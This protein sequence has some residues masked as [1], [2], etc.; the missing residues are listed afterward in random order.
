MSI[1]ALSAWLILLYPIAT[2]LTAGLHGEVA[3]RIQQAALFASTLAWLALAPNAERGADPH[4]RG[5]L[6]TMLVIAILARLLLL[7]LAPSDDLYRYLWEGR[8][9]A[10]GF[11]PYRLAPDSPQLAPLRD[12][13]WPQI[14][15]PDHAA[16][17][18]PL[19][20]WLFSCVVRL[21]ATVVAMKLFVVL[22]DMA[23]I[24]VLWRIGRDAA[25]RYALCPLVLRSF[26]HEAHL[27]ALLVLGLAVILW[28]QHSRGN[29]PRVDS[30]PIAT[31][32]PRIAA[33]RD[34]AIATLG[35][36]LAIGAKWVGGLAVLAIR[37]SWS[38]LS[39]VVAIAIAIAPLATFAPLDARA[40]SPLLNF[41]TEFRTLDLGQ[42]WI[43]T[44]VAPLAGPPLA[45][46]VSPADARPA[47]LVATGLTLAVIVW[48]SLR[49]KP[50]AAAMQRRLF[51]GLLL[52][53]P[54]VHF[55]YAAWLVPGIS[56][57]A[58]S[59]WRWLMLSMIFALEADAIRA[60]TGEWRQPV[61]VSYAVFMPV[62]IALAF[63]RFRGSANRQ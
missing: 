61:W 4:R 11:D 24:C 5:K 48:L 32:S 49:G 60:A 40:F 15:H 27:D 25:A 62:L 13:N 30:S 3:I 45:V 18:P 56:L 59:P 57:A 6:A 46:A 26:A 51:G 52:I 44:L 43:D 34:F 31:S 41:A 58:S 63:A 28:V 1:V 39:L 9:V 8:V 53:L 36:A 17:Y 22:A 19:V 12:A 42:R 21:S 10:A 20:L 23:T 29:S 47:R 14:N 50:D 38:P 33:S 35:L 55:W 7:P 37:R 2:I 54:T 16:I